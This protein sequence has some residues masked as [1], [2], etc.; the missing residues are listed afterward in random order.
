MMPLL[1]PALAFLLGLF[2]AALAPNL[3]AWAWLIPL[4]PALLLTALDRRLRR[5]FAGYAALR[6]REALALPAGVLL[7]LALLGAF[8]LAAARPSF[9]V[10]DLAY[11]NGQGPAS[12]IGVVVAEPDRRDRATLARV[13]VERIDLPGMAPVTARGTALL[14]LPA[15]ASLRYGDRVEVRGEPLAPPE[16]EGF[17]YRA[18]LSRQCVYTYLT[19]PRVRVI[20]QGPRNPFW[21][22]TYALRQKAAAVI[23]RAYPQPEAAL[24]SGVL[25]GLEQDLPSDLERAFQ[26]TG[27]AHIIAIS[28]F[29]MAILAALILRLFGRLLP[30]GP[31]AL[32]AALTI[33]FYTLLVGANPAV[34]RAAILG[35]SGLLAGYLGRKQAGLNSLALVAALMCLLDPDL[36]WD[37][38]FQ[39]S[40]TATLGLVLYADRLQT[41]FNAW[42]GRRLPQGWG[43]RLAGPL[44]EY[45]L[46]TLAAQVTT[47]PVTLYHF[48]RLS[49]LALVAN[50]LVLPPQ[51]ALMV[52]GG[53]SVLAGLIYAPLGQALA[54]VAWPLAAYTTRMVA[55]L[56]G[57]PVAGLSLGPVPAGVAL[58]LYAA[59][60]AL[61]LLPRARPAMWQVLRPAFLVTGV[62]LLA[63]FTWR[64]VITEPDG[65]LHLSLLNLEGGPAVLAQT[66]GGNAVLLGGAVSA[67][68]LSD[69]LGRRLP[70][71]G[72]SLSAVILTRA[73]SALEG[74]P[75]TLERFPPERAYWAVPV[76]ARATGKRVSNGL[77]DASVPVELLQ[78][79]AGLDLGSGVQLSV[80]ASQTDRAAVMV[81]YR[82]FRL[83]IPNGIP[84][85]KLGEGGR[86]ASLLLLTGADLKETEP[87]A[88]Q[89]LE[90]QGVLVFAPGPLDLPE[91]WQRLDGS[92]ELV[93]DGEQMWLSGVR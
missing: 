31:A 52:L 86:A 76:S 78:P 50:P 9:G 44:G 19:L 66:P 28:G 20:G 63:A 3:P 23:Q 77:A 70:P 59:L 42:A 91:H 7:A 87:A 21:V 22:F 29:N 1:W 4:A 82:G 56:A 54:A 74:L 15:G 2:A 39:L 27:T 37:A 93:S 49:P 41:A 57:L 24:L 89:S 64:N 35:A 11:Y 43:R 32:A 47:L 92:V 8:R 5:R 79:N 80:L 88:W 69:E 33:G 81:T 84:P 34:V 68:R 53:L 46:V 16:D 26:D 60:F 45:F 14:R 72:R 71:A 18:Y 85:G 51:P 55:A 36:P 67:N 62:A 61:T 6:R 13:Q 17:S 12:L 83:L 40:F 48:Q 25:L 75:L 58:A 38:S 30:V 65:R 10:G 73:G 90:P